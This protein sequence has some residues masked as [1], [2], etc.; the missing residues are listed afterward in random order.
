MSGAWTARVSSDCKRVLFLGP[1]GRVSARVIEG[2]ELRG[3]VLKAVVS[4]GS[5]S[6]VREIVRGGNLTCKGLDVTMQ[7]PGRPRQTMRFEGVE[8]I[9]PALI[10]DLRDVYELRR[11]PGQLSAEMSKSRSVAGKAS[12][13]ARRAR[14]GR[15]LDGEETDG[16][17][18]PE[19]QEDVA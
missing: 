5:P 14:R 1:E 6:K 8:V 17:Q 3:E 2:G 18:P 19:G 16:Q 9:P 7:A 13:A 11:S 10:R 4:L 12:V 15:W